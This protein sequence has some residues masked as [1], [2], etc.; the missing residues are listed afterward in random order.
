MGSNRLV[1]KNI[2]KFRI[3]WDIPIKRGPKKQFGKFQFRVKQLLKPHWENH[4]VYEEVPVA[5]K[6]G[7]RGKSVDILNL[8]TRQIIEVQGK[9]HGEFIQGMFHKNR[10]DFLKQLKRDEFKKEWALLNDF[11]FYEIFEED[12]LDENLLKR[13]DII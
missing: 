2:E 13:L 8:T 1:S 6:V 4:I 7:E 10:F 5:A 9:A 3:N 12:I 11:R